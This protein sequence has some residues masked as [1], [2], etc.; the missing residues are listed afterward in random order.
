MPKAGHHVNEAEERTAVLFEELLQLVGVHSR[1][2]DVPAQAVN[3]QQTQRKQNPLTQFRD[4]KDVGQF[5]QHLLQY[6]EFAAC[7]GNL[8]LG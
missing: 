5:F 3:G 4:T 2:G 6:L 1:S 7:F 8:F